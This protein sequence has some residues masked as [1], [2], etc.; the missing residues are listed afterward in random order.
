MLVM[1]W[2]CCHRTKQ[3]LFNRHA[4]AFDVCSV[5]LYQ[6]LWFLASN[7]LEKGFKP[8]ISHRRVAR[9]TPLGRRIG[10]LADIWGRYYS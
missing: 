1:I 4:F 9:F 5:P 2:Q 8:L 7:N 10:P 3:A 6:Q